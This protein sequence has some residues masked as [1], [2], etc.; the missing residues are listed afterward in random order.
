MITMT[1]QIGNSDN[2]LTQEMWA[3]YHADVNDLLNPEVYAKDALTVHFHGAS[4]SYEKWQNICWVITLEE[5]SDLDDFILRNLTVI[6][7]AYNQDSIA[8]HRGVVEFI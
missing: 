6:R 7:K 3:N 4:S 8:I 5:L 1:V 2:K